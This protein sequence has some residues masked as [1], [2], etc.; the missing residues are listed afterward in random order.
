LYTL[1]YNSRYFVTHSEVQIK[2]NRK[3]PG[4]ANTLDMVII[5]KK[6]GIIFEYKVDCIVKICFKASCADLES[7]FQVYTGSF[8]TNF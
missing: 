6:I 5:F 2:K 8:K 7:G 3:S 4:I 1:A